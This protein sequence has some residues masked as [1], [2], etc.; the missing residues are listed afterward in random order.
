MKRIAISFL[1]LT[2]AFALGTDVL[3]WWSVP[4]I[5]LLYGIMA[6]PG[7]GQ[8]L[9]AALAAAFAWAIL[10][11]LTAAQ[12]P[13]GPLADKLGGI[14]RVPGPALY[15]ITC[16]FPFFIAGCATGLVSAIKGK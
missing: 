3:G 7:R 12:G 5:G 1:L 4:A 11:L 8:G 6:R 10:L 15:V 2:F 14:M 16:M 9:L 13:V